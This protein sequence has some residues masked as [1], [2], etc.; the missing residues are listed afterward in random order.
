MQHRVDH[1]LPACARR[2]RL[3]DRL[4]QRALRRR[5][6]WVAMAASADLRFET[7]RPCEY[8]AVLKILLIL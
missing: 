7:G 8:V 3:A 5:D 2:K 1:V 4:I 6:A